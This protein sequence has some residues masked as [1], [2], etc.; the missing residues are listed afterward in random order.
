MLQEF[1]GLLLSQI[2]GTFLFFIGKKEEARF[3]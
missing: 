2:R 3:A 1:F